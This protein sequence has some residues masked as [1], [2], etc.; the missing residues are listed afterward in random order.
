M[1]LTTPNIKCR[2]DIAEIDLVVHDLNNLQ[3]FIDVARHSA[4]PGSTVT[5]TLVELLS[6][7]SEKLQTTIEKLN[8]KDKG[9]T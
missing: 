3:S 1:Q 6:M 8:Q 5:P 7:I 2:E 9:Q 4:I